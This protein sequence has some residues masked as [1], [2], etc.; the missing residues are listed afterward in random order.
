MLFI[1]RY[2]LLQNAETAE[3]S[4]YLFDKETVK[5]SQG[6]ICHIVVETT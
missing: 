4:P 5:D 1:L 3:S 6:K 2:S